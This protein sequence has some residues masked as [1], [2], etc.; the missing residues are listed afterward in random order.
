[1]D[2]LT[3]RDRLVK[4][5]PEQVQQVGHL[6]SLR[7]IS[8]LTGHPRALRALLLVC[9]LTFLCPLLCVL[10]PCEQSVRELL[11]MADH[12]WQCKSAASNRAYGDNVTAIVA[13]ITNVV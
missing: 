9:A 6:G 2:E 11:E 3:I 10:P 5:R 1:M 7:S 4:A 8:S 12:R 13:K